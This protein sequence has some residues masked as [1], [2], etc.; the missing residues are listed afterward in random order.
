MMFFG[1]V[2]ATTGVRMRE[3]EILVLLGVPEDALKAL[4]AGMALEEAALPKSGEIRVID[5]IDLL[6]EPTP[7]Q[8]RIDIVK[9]LEF[10]DLMLDFLRPLPFHK[11]RPFH[12]QELRP[13]NFTGGVPRPHQARRPVTIHRRLQ[14]GR[15]M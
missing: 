10:D 6:F 15:N 14:R 11:E 4:A 3:D 9:R 1:K 12:F 13:H 2:H 7:E 8:V 5:L